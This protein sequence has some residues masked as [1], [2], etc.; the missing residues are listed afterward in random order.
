MNV[1]TRYLGAGATGLVMASAAS[2][3]CR[4]ELDEL[5]ASVEQ[6]DT[7]KM[8]TIDAVR[9]DDAEATDAPSA[10]DTL[11]EPGSFEAELGEI[12]AANEAQLQEMKTEDAAPSIANS[13][14]AQDRSA[15]LQEAR[16]ALDAGDE[17]AC[18]AA[19]ERAR[20]L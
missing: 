2:A 11:E 1:I 7:A 18:L 13:V 19:V 14:A 5:I 6:T 12:Q 10:E 20:G 8:Q 16:T 9:E 15:A 17:A 3:D 4:A